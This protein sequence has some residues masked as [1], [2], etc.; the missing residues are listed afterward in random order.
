MI[1]GLSSSRLPGA[2]PNRKVFKKSG[3][4]KMGP[5]G[6][7]KNNS[8]KYIRK[9]IQGWNINQVLSASKV[10][11]VNFIRSQDSVVPPPNNVP[12][13][14]SLRLFSNMFYLKAL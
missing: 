2:V 9:N 7:I 13:L 4:E 12:A 1:T 5:T 10:R 11:R 3:Y 14:E 6:K 8:Y